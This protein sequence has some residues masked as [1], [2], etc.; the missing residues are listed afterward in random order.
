LIE[1]GFAADVE[2]AARVGESE[3]VPVLSGEAFVAQPS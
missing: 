2:L 3:C 1:R